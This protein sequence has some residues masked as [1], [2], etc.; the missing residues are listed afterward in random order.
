MVGCA[1]VQDS[2][3]FQVQEGRPRAGPNDGFLNQLAVFERTIAEE[4]SGSLEP[5]ESCAALHVQQI[6]EK[7][8]KNAQFLKARQILS[9]KA[10]GSLFTSDFEHSTLIPYEGYESGR[11][12]RKINIFRCPL[13]PKKE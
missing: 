6:L 11:Q 3:L 1:Q 13:P 9:E 8:Q 5:P 2:V 10:G 7:G 4:K 12:H